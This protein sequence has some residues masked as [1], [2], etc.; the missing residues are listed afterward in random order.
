MNKYLKVE[1]KRATLSK[2][3][4]IVFIITLLA[5]IIAYVEANGIKGQH[6]LSEYDAV[7]IFM[8]IRWA[9]RASYLVIIAPL[10][11]TLVFSDSYL[12]EKEYGYL[13]NIYTKMT[14]RRYIFT[15]ITVNAVVSG[16]IITIAYFIMLAILI[17]IHGINKATN[18]PILETTLFSY[19]YY[20]HRFL[21][22]LVLIVNS[23]IFNAICATLAL[24]ISPWIKNRYL[25]CLCP[26]FYWIFSG[27]I[28]PHCM[29][30]NI[31]FTMNGDVTEL[32]VI[33]YQVILFVIG[34]TSF[35]V[36]VRYP[37]EKDL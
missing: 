2:N 7:Y 15:K 16:M 6:F 35:Y 28:L 12:L 25:T 29:D 18:P 8:H 23:F 10:L 14:K 33:V 21:Y 37:Y 36:G 3:T 19:I 4:I 9:E 5:L 24:G 17:A 30:L 26:F 1:F 22:A 32:N 13:K 27:I 34:I 31:L 20:K 11:A